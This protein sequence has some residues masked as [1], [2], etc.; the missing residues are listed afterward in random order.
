MVA[1]NW[2]TLHLGLPRFCSPSHSWFIGLE[3]C[4]VHTCKS[5]FVNNKNEYLKLLYSFFIQMGSLQT[6]LYFMLALCYTLWNSFKC[7]ICCKTNNAFKWIS[8]DILNEFLLISQLNSPWYLNW[9]TPDISSEFLLIS[10]LNSSWYLN[11]ITP[12]IST[13]FPLISQLNFPWNLFSIPFDIS[14]EF[15]KI[16]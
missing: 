7:V 6:L 14:T 3:L 11:W 1:E 9:N 13:K 16:S 12:D 4:T 8:P 5:G 10:Q 15:L 2:T